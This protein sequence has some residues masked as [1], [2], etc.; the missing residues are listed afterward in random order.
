MA[1]PLKSLTGVVLGVVHKVIRPSTA[2]RGVV[3]EIGH[4]IPPEVLDT[5]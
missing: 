3:I 5:V 1:N 4:V 2:G